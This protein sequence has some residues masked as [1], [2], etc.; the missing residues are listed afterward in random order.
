M[1]YTDKF[2]YHYYLS[3]SINNTATIPILVIT[4]VNILLFVITIV[5]ILLFVITIVNI[6]LIVITIVNIL[7]FVITKVNILLFVITKVNILLFVIT[8]VNILL[9]VIISK[10]IV[11]I[12]LTNFFAAGSRKGAVTPS[13]QELR[14]VIIC[15]FS[16]IQHRQPSQLNHI[17]GR[18]ILPPLS[19]SRRARAETRSPVI[20]LASSAGSFA[21]TNTFDWLSGRGEKRRG[22]PRKGRNC[23]LQL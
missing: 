14:V 6:L 1:I 9:F 12:V 17:W 3:Y 15:F 16:F 11:V 21:I 18:C 4:I 5:N 19:C 13:F 10:I 23:N 20:N 8:K 2:T 7:L 22:T